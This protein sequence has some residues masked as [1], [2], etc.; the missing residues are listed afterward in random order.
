MFDF[1]DLDSK[2]V[3]FAVAMAF[4]LL[5]I[6][7]GLAQAAYNQELNSNRMRRGFWHKIAIVMMLA[8]A[9]IVDM[10]ISAGLGMPISAPVFEGSCI[11]I[12]TM[13]LISLSEN[14]CNMNDELAKSP[15]MRVL[16]RI[17]AQQDDEE[18]EPHA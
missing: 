1:S 10:G 13:E 17:K 5:D 2:S 7:S 6:L 15:L 18:G 16:G 9:G 12:A 8:A 4:M 14:L 3:F 11:Y